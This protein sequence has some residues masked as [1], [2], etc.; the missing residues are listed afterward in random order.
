MPHAID[1]VDNMVLLLH[2]PCYHVDN[3]V[4]LIQLHIPQSMLSTKGT[5]LLQH[6]HKVDSP[7][8][9]TKM[10]FRAQGVF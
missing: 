9:D 7:D 10:E 4:I 6:S 3:M 2:L 1:S 8:P 5:K